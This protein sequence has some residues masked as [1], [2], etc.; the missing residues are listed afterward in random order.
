VLPAIR[1]RLS[2]S[3][4]K[5]IVLDDDPTGTQ[6]VH[7]VSV[8]TE[9]TVQAIRDV[10]AGTDPVEAAAAFVLT[11]SRSLGEPEARALN[12]SIGRN[13]VE[14]S[15]QA[16]RGFLVVSRSDST[17]RGHYPAE[18]EE[19]AAALGG[20]FDGTLIVPF[21]EAGGR[22][23]VG[24]VH[25]V[26]E[27]ETLVPAGRTAFARDPAFGYASSNLR[28]WVEEKTSGR[29]PADRVR[30]LSIEDIREGG[31]DGVAALLAGLGDGS[32]CAVNAACRRD[33][34]VVAL[35]A[36][37][38]EGE[39]RRFLYRTAASFAAAVAGVG[40]RPLLA[41]DELDLPERGGALVVF[42]SHVPRSTEQLLHLLRDRDVDSAELRVC[43]VLDDEARAPA[44][45]AAAASADEALARDRDFVVYT[46]R[47]PVRADA[48]ARRGGRDSLGV[49]RRVSDALVSV[50]RAVRAR[51]RY[52]LAKGGVT[53]SDVA[54]AA[55]DVRRAT[56]LGQVSPG[57]P[58][59]RLGPEA[60]FPGMAYVVFP[61]NVGGEAAVTEIVDRLG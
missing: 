24:D 26:L 16:G 28:E 4:R 59:W 34:E 8:V 47:E 52:V 58:V 56:V 42:G 40:P 20:A 17:L 2:G 9:W 3:G 36:L 11:N 30:T 49:G 27:G 35:A 48:G 22:L 19:L 39:G 53:S 46:S 12:R 60:R 45:A 25:Y 61:G 5:V 1:A 7:G 54:T 15:R 31:P 18:V 32:V 43:E 44:V 33:A 50:V 55:L 10:L 23:T 51:P 13:L 21:F 41:R 57:V 29:V 6:T 14:A 38:A 37:E